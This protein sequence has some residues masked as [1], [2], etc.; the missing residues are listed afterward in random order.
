[1]RIPLRRHDQPSAS[2][3]AYTICEGRLPGGAT[4]LDPNHDW[5]AYTI[6]E[7]Q[8]GAWARCKLKDDQGNLY[9]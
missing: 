8:I 7:I 1:M 3:I 6:E 2:K 4:L 9:S 5:N